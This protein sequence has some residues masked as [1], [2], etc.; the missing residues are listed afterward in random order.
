MR[1]REVAQLLENIATLLEM[2]GEN[3]FKIVAYEEAARRIESWPE[4]IEEVWKE[5]RLKEIPGV[6]ESIASK[7]EEYLST[8]KLSYLEELTK[9]I[10][11]EVV[12]LTAIP[13]WGLRLLSFSTT[14]WG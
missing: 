11:P 3:R 13:E 14:S 12:H 9:E 2:K 5:G 6:G 10:P 7:I 8:G 1:N 4:P